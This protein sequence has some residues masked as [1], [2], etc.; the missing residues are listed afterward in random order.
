LQASPAAAGAAPLVAGEAVP[1]STAK[2]GDRNRS[3]AQAAGGLADLRARL[4]PGTLGPVRLTVAGAIV[5]GA[6]LAAWVQWQPQ[7]STDASQQALS[8]LAHDPHGALTSAQ[9]A[10]SRDPLS[11]QALFTL[12]AVQQATGAPVLARAT[13]QRAV[14][15]QP[16]NPQTWLTLGEYDLEHG[17]PLNAVHE[18]EAAIYLNPESVAPEAIAAG[19]P[20]AISIQ[21][22]YV[23]ALRATA[24]Q[25]S[26]A[27]SAS[28]ARR[29]AARAAHRAAHQR[30][31][32]RSA[33]SRSPA[34][35]R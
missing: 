2:T 19:N 3:G 26:A 12:S 1:T 32:A 25:Q 21:N 7:R 18:L 8:E 4:S 14:R 27:R 22:A 5:V 28:A 6:L 34:K 13:L 31:A 33:R 17:N 30:R 16:S 20:E 23:Q 35:G 24:A 9:T 15:L 10:V 29:R 11:A